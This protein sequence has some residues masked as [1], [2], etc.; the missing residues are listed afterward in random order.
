VAIA[1]HFRS[2]Q[3]GADRRVLLLEAL[4]ATAGGDSAQVSVHNISQTGLLLETEA[5]LALGEMIELELPE[6]GVVE[7]RVVWLSEN[8]AGCAF[9]EPIGD[10]AL[11]AAQL[12]GAA[13]ASAADAAPGYES[14]PARFARLRKARGLT[15]AA[16]AE[17]LGVSK[18][19]VWAWE[20]GKARPVEERLT[21][22]A[23]VLGVD[24]SEL[25]SDRHVSNFAD[26]AAVPPV[27]VRSRAA[28]AAALGISAQRIRISI[29]L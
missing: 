10:A 23:A 22:L 6:A 11:S 15:L 8:L 17:V 20:Q 24:R 7:A 3:R 29:E 12:R 5:S 21:P 4:G 26:S 2:D 13:V 25:A 1:A 14:F 27:V 9:V 19:T 18:P 28:I 16:V